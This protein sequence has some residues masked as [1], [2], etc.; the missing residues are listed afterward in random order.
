MLTVA[1]RYMEE[2]TRDSNGICC[3][4]DIAVSVS[5]MLKALVGG[6][7]SRVEAMSSAGGWLPSCAMVKIMDLDA[8]NLLSL[9]LLADAFYGMQLVFDCGSYG[10]IVF[11]Q[12]Q[13]YGFGR[14]V[15]KLLVVARHRQ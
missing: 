12:R 1:A 13:V 2:A 6:V 9:F 15:D 10:E 7:A 5:P 4:S 8:L 14:V 3:L 11:V